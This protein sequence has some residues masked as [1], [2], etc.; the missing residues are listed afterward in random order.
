M[1]KNFSRLKTGLVTLWIAI[2][3]FFSKVVWQEPIL[4]PMYWV[5]W[6]SLEIEKRPTLIY[7]ISN[8]ITRLIWLILVPLLLI[9]GIVNIKKIIKIKDKAQ[10][11]KKIKKTIITLLLILI[12]AVVLYILLRLLVRFLLKNDSTY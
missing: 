6:P 8:W 4:Y 3:S 11:K 1:K 12:W 10:R 9:V 2:I 5:P 7:T